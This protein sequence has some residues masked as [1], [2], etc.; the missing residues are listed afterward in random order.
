MRAFTHTQTCTDVCAHVHKHTRVD[1]HTHTHTYRGTR[2]RHTGTR[3]H[4]L[5]Y[6]HVRMHI[7]KHV[8]TRRHTYTHASGHSGMYVCIRRHTYMHAW[9]LAS[10][11]A[12]HSYRCTYVDT[13]VQQTKCVTQYKHT[14][15]QLHSTHPYCSCMFV[16]I[17]IA[18]VLS[19]KTQRFKFIS[20]HCP[21]TPHS[22]A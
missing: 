14:Y 9:V 21:G 15:T 22:C 16:W 8:D 19:Q 1:T 10:L 5:L 7:H 4:T 20:C 6:T 2:I 17:E 3:A 18:L 12:Q 13:S 11:H